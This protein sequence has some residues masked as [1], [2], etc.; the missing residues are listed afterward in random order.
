MIQETLFHAEW[1]IKES[2]ILALGAIGRRQLALLVGVIESGA[3]LGFEGGGGQEV[4]T[5]T[6]TSLGVIHP[7]PPLSLS[8]DL[9]RG[10][11]QTQ[12]RK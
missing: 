4:N 11:K 5:P 7:P 12:G 6:L 2:G 10:C 8:F 9:N 3:H 1:E